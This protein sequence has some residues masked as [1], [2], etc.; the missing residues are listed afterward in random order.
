[1]PELPEVEALA[2]YLR[3]RAVG[4]CVDRLEVAAISALKTY[5]PAP[6]AVAGRAVTDARRHGK[7]LDIAFDGG[8]HLVVHL[9]RAGWLHYRE[10]FASNVPLRPGKGPIAVRVRLDDGS[11]F[12]LTEAGTQKKL[13]AYLVTDPQAV[14]GVAKLGPDALSADL[15][16]FAGALRGRRGQVKGVLTDQGVLG[17]V[18]N[19]YS[20]EIL[21]E[22]KLSP[23]ALTDRLTDDQMAG[24]HAATRRVLG[25]AVTRSLGQRA[26]ELKGEKRSGLRVHART[27]LPCPVCG[28]TVRAVSFADSSLQYCPTCQTGGKPLADRRL[29]RI[30]R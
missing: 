5:D 4:R 23:F 30:V 28:D 26:A 16:T 20:D 22:A 15:A 12:D 8:L 21:H 29:S 11:G 3:Q 14:P 13:A 10:A 17:G 25:D 27:G 9:A 6:T 24:L 18:G 1:M 7:F 19:A 2:G